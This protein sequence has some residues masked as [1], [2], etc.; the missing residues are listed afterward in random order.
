MELRQLTTDH[1]RQIFAKC[2]TEA[3]ATR[4]IRFQGNLAL[5]DWQGAHPIRKSVRAVRR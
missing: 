5:G 1:E 3:R 4:G 2:L